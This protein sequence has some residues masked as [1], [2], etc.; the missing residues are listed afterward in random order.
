MKYDVHFT[1]TVSATVT[2]EADDPEQA[3]EKAYGSESMPGWITVGAFGGG[4]VVDSSG[5]WDPCEVTDS[6]G[7]TV[8]TDEN[9]GETDS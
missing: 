3:I 9:A 7:E 8:W 2:V 6:A 5:D 1:H 4:A